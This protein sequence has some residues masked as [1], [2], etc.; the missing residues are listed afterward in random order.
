MVMTIY[1]PDKFGQES[2]NPRL[3]LGQMGKGWK[4]QSGGVSTEKQGLWL[5][6]T[7]FWKTELEANF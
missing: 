4:G 7:E 3:M 2:P 5:S 1:H 6:R